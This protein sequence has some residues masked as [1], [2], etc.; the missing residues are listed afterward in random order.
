MNIQK[1]WVGYIVWGLFSIVL[2]SN[3]AFVALKLVDNGTSTFS[4]IVTIGISF[5]V[6]ILGSVTFIL[7]FKLFMKYLYHKLFTEQQENTG[8]KSFVEIILFIFVLFTAILLR[9]IVLVAIGGEY[10]GDDT[11]YRLSLGVLTYSAAGVK[12]NGAFIYS[13]LLNIIFNIFGKKF[14]A[15]LIFQLILQIGTVF[16]TFM[17]VKRA[18]GKVPAWISLFCLAFLPGNFI[19]VNTMNP[20]LFFLFFFTLFFW[21]L[22][23]SVNENYVKPSNQFIHCCSYVILGLL[24]AFLC[25][26][27]ISGF[28]SVIIAIVF[29]LYKNKNKEDD[30]YSFEQKTSTRILLYLCSFLLCLFLLLFFISSNETNGFDAIIEYLQ[31]FVPHKGF[32]LYLITPTALYWDCLIP[33]FLVALWF[34][35][36]FRVNSSNGIPFAL[37][38]IVLFVLAFLKLD[39]FSYELFYNL[40]WAILA[41]IGIQ[42][43]AAY[44][45]N[46]NEESRVKH[47]RQSKKAQREL[48]RSFEAGEKSIQL[49]NLDPQ[50]VDPPSPRLDSDDIPRSY[51]V[52]RKENIPMPSQVPPVSTALP[53]E[54]KNVEEPVKAPTSQAKSKMAQVPVLP[55]DIIP[56][57]TNKPTTTVT[58]MN[59]NQTQTTSATPSENKANV[60]IEKKL[61]DNMI[62]QNTVVKQAPIRRGYRTPSK[63][64]FSPEELE[65]I[66]Q[67]TNGEF[68]Y[69]TK[70]D[71]MNTSSVQKHET[72]LKNNFINV[73]PD[74]RPQTVEAVNIAKEELKENISHNGSDENTTTVPLQSQA[75]LVNGNN[76]K[77]TETPSLPPLVKD[78]L[79]EEKPKLIKNPLPGPKPHVTRELSYDYI[80]KESEMDFDL[81]DLSGKDYY[82]I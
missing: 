7:L 29:L 68:D 20:A 69:H 30:S 2:F 5:A 66:R 6:A 53:E 38:I 22:A 14:Q 75:Q 72:V 42:S 80:P 3:T 44:I 82:D 32:D 77:P 10:T 23:L 45:P 18:F 52:G 19:A 56:A 21:I 34:F 58:T 59:T 33:L 70:E 57:Q 74:S 13:E 65:R 67:H 39:I 79:V 61:E 31:L 43:L 78:K 24:S 11:Y 8:E 51:G 17:G 71:M 47:E 64:T 25:Y 41:G 28:I 46:S 26:Y 12:T 9:S 76:D 1:N 16:F 40:L 50:K 4:Y 73:I 27:D 54:T 36:Y 37:S 62:I 63:S 60:Q 35:S 81:K 49:N 48:K 55:K 15:G